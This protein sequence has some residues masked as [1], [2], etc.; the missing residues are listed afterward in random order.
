M[1]NR[2]QRQGRLP[3]GPGVVLKIEKEIDTSFTFTYS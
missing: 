2:V 1:L 3:Q